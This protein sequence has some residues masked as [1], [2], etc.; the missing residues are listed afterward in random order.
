MHL[1]EVIHEPLLQRA[2]AGFGMP[3]MYRKLGTDIR[4]TLRAC[5]WAVAC[6][7]L[8]LSSADAKGPEMRVDPFNFRPEPGVDYRVSVIHAV[9]DSYLPEEMRAHRGDKTARELALRG[10]AWAKSELKRQYPQYDDAQ[11][12]EMNER[13]AIDDPRLVRVVI[14]KANQ[15]EVVV[16]HLLLVYDDLKKPLP[17]DHVFGRYSRPEQGFRSYNE[18][19]LMTWSWKKSLQ[20]TGG[21]VQLMEFVI[22]PSAKG[23]LNAVLHF[24]SEYMLGGSSVDLPHVRVPW[25]RFPRGKTREDF[26]GQ[27][28]PSNSR[29]AEFALLPHEYILFCD[30]SMVDYYERLGFT[31]IKRKGPLRGMLI[32][33]EAFS[34][35]SSDSPFFKRSYRKLDTFGLDMDAFGDGNPKGRGLVYPPGEDPNR[36]GEN[37]E[38]RL[39]R[40]RRINQCKAGLSSGT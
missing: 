39:E 1:F 19:D 7:V 9:K 32:S 8:A 35:I 2:Y 16:G 15:P 29:S 28:L 6:V 36:H 37:I 3:A 34:K 33:R 10:H 4:K 13:M 22:D 21:V 26:Y 40:F 23:D 25:S 18:Y 38:Q 14:T 31:I 27:Y 5:L 17:W 24:A 11:F 12:E 20:Y 30:V